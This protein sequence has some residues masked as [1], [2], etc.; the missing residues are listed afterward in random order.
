MLTFSIDLIASTLADPYL[1]Y[2]GA[3]YALA[4][5]LHG[6]VIANDVVQ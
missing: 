6:Y 4:G 2:A 3:L 5:P 1:A